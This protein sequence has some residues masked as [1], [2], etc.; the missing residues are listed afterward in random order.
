MGV[1]LKYNE[2]TKVVSVRVAKSKYNIFKPLIL[3][4][5]DR[6]HKKRKLI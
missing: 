4:Y 3:K 2:E 1:K 5:A 6:L